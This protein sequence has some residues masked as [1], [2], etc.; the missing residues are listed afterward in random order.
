AADF[1]AGAFDIQE[2]VVI[3]DGTNVTFKLKTRDLSPT[4]G[5][6]LGA[7]LV[8]VYV[9]TPNAAPADTSTAASFPQRNYQIAPAAA[10]SRRIEVQAF[11][12]RYIGA[13]NNVLGQATTSANAIS[14]FI[15]F[16]VPES[17]LGKP[18]SGWSFSV[19]LTG[20]DGF[21]PDQAR[22]FAATPQQFAFGVCASTSSDSH[23]S[24]DPTTV[25][26]AVDVLT[27]PGVQQS[28]E[29]DYTRHTPV[30]IQAVTVL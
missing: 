6:P 26:K 28:D 22:G 23:C 10:W 29:L 7:Q 5:S 19:V 20:Q 24:V 13:H 9:H 12:Q 27:P 11:G 1:H 17:S 21:A 2:F 30:V 4:F 8:D 25:P 14:R 3:D 15:T 18:G 16:R